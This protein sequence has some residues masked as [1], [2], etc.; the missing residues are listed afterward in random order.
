MTGSDLIEQVSLAHPFFETAQSNLPLP[1]EAP[2][3]IA[4]TTNKGEVAQHD[5]LASHHPQRDR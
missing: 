4:E 1:N 3:G 2:C 5:Q